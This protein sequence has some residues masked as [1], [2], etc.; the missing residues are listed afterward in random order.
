MV[1]TPW[2]VFGS[3]HK[4][5]GTPDTVWL[6]RCGQ[7]GW[8]AIAKDTKILEHA[9]ELAALRQS[10]IHI[11]YYPGNATRA[12]LLAAAA[13]TLAEVCTITSQAGGGAWRIRG[14]RKPHVEGI[15]F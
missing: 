3:R 6:R 11:F 8:A 4:A 7:G 12:E 9:D 13:V 2:K 14:G 5:Q 1:H 10:K 15:E